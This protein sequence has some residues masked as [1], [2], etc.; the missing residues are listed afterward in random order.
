MAENLINQEKKW[1]ALTASTRSGGWDGTERPSV[2]VP[3]RDSSRGPVSQATSA[4][5]S[6]GAN[7]GT[8]GPPKPFWAYVAPP[9]ETKPKGGR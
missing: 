9:S 1:A 7:V 2:D 8:G 3:S 4:A 6:T 5:T